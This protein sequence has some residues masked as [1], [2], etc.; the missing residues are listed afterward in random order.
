MAAL[1]KE[2][3]TIT[4]VA[5][6]IGFMAPEVILDEPSDFK[7]DV[8]SLGI[9][10]YALLSSNVPFEGENRDETARMI[11]E[12]DVVFEDFRFLAVSEP[13]KDLIR[14]MLAKDQRERPSLKQVLQHPWFAESD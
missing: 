12:E 9:M 11:V 2:G 7:A 6:T 13:C 8:W 1:L 3:E 5:G 4:K 10:L 14:S